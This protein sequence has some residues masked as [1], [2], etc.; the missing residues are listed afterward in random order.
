MNC[1]QSRQLSAYYDG[2]LRPEECR[3]LEAHLAECAVCRTELAHLRTL[4]RLVAGVGE[5]DVPEGLALRV[6]ERVDSA[7]DVVVVRLAERLMAV[8]AVVMLASGVWLW[9]AKETEASPPVE[10]L[11]SIIASPTLPTPQEQAPVDP[12]IKWVVDDLS[13]GERT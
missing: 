7:G 11:G 6:H 4:S 1:E 3:S 12:V 8:A 2:E 13:Q 9:Q 5:S 10:S